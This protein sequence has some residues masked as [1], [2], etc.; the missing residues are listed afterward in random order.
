[1]LIGPKIYRVAT[2]LDSFL[3]L[4]LLHLFLIVGTAK[5]GT[6]CWGPDDP[7]IGQPT[8]FFHLAVE[9]LSTHF[10]V[11][12]AIDENILE[13]SSA[14]FFWIWL[15]QFLCYYACRVHSG[16]RNVTI[17]RPSV[18]LSVCLSRQHTATH[19]RQYAT[20][21][22]YISAWQQRRPI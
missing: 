19:Q 1:V 2:P 4:L 14:D 15:Y 3:H 8:L 5:N 12:I 7:R 20:R 11:K 22:A 13:S 10:V 21:P 6:T 18:C 9:L 17:W 16:K